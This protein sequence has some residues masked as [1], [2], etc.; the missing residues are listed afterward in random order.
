MS[1]FVQI[2]SS[3][4]VPNVWNAAKM[5]R[6]KLTLVLYPSVWEGKVRKT[7]VSTPFY[8]I[9]IPNLIRDFLFFYFYRYLT[10]RH[11]CFC[12]WGR[13]V[14]SLVYWC[15]SSDRSLWKYTANH[16][17]SWRTKPGKQLFS[18]CYFLHQQQQQHQ[19]PK[20]R[21]WSVS[22]RRYLR[23]WIWIITVLCLIILS[24]HPGYIADHRHVDAYTALFFFLSGCVR[25]VNPSN[26]PFTRVCLLNVW[27][28]TL[29]VI[30]KYFHA[31]SLVQHAF[32]FVVV[33][34]F[35]RFNFLVTY[36][37]ICMTVVSLQY[38][39]IL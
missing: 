31:R 3:G 28:H 39:H 11:F 22:W 23:K 30:C 32:F 20:Y 37:D 38:G 29:F 26:L 6:S 10:Y 35:F 9:S 4:T 19:Q 14:D 16:P 2:V 15:I 5:S 17:S 34:L 27:G 18:H 7:C 25:L 33:F 1:F 24:V 21:L 13:T 12:Y 8:F 36:I